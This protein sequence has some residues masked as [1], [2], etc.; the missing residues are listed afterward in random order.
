MKLIF[1]LPLLAAAA[2]T[3]SP[4]LAE[5]ALWIAEGNGS[6][7]GGVYRVDA[8]KAGRPESYTLRLNDKKL[9]NFSITG[10]VKLPNQ[11]T[12]KIALSG[13][14]NEDGIAFQRVAKGEQI[15]VGPRTRANG[16]PVDEAMPF[17][18]HLLGNY[19][20]V[21]LGPL[22]EFRR[23][24]K[25]P[26]DLAMILHGSG[27]EVGELTVKPLQTGGY[28]PILSLPQK[29]NATLETWI[30][31][32]LPSSGFLESRGVPFFFSPAKALDVAT[33]MSG[34]KEP[35]RNKKGYFAEST[36]NT[37]GRVGLKIPGDQFSALHLLA[38][39]PGREGHVPRMTV[40]VGFYGNSSGILED[41]VVEVPRLAGGEKT[42]WV[43]GEFP[44]TLPD[45]K[46]G[47]VYHLRV[48][49]AKTANVREFEI[50]DL[51]FTRD[52]NT[53]V[54]PPDPNEFGKIA[55][56]YP[57][58]A[59]VLAAS[60]E[61]S[62]VTMV[63]TTKE[64][65]N[66]FFET[67]KAE[68]ELTLSNRSS[69]PQTIIAYATGAGPG[70]GEEYGIEHTPFSV[71][72]KV[73]LAPGETR[74]IT[75]DVTQKRRGWYRCSVGIKQDGAVLQQRE[76]TFGIL[77]PDTRKAG[78]ES[79]FGSWQ[80]WNAHSVRPTAD[81]IDRLASLMHKA[82]FR[83][84]YGGVP[85]LSRGETPDLDEVYDRLRN[86]YKIS[87]TIQNLPKS[88]Q[89][90]EGWWNRE[91][92]ET[93]VKPAIETGLRRSDGYFKV[94]HESRSSP[95]LIRRFSPYFGGDPY[96]MPAEEKARLDRQVENVTQYT[97]ALKQADPRAKVV[98]INDYPAFA[99]QYL[100]RK[101]PP[102]NFDVIGLEG[103]MF[104]RAPERQPDWMSLLGLLRE[105]RLSMEKHGYKKP[106]WTTE[107]LYHPTEAGALSLH[108]QATINVR[109]AMMA[110]QLG[111]ERMA[112]A[113]NIQDYSDDYHWTNWGSV[114]H[115]YRD[116]EFN[117][118]PSYLAYAWLTQILDQAKP[119][120]KIP[121][122]NP[123]LHLV[124]FVKP[125]G[126]H[127]YGLWTAGGVQEVR[128]RYAGGSQPVVYD[129]YGNRVEQTKVIAASTAPH[130]VEGAVVEGI[131]AVEPVELP[132]PN[133]GDVVTEFD[134][135]D[136]FE[137]VQGT[138]AVLEKNWE[139][140]YL[141]GGFKT[142]WVTVDNATALKVELQ[143]DSDP[144]KLFP[145]YIELKFK[146]PVQLPGRPHELVF[147]VKGNSGWG[148]I[149]F[150]MVDAKGRVWTSV[151]NQY[152][153]AA[154]AADPLGE[155]FVNFEGWQTM[156]F[157]VMG[158][159]PGKDQTLF[160]PKNYNWWPW[161]AP[162]IDEARKAEMVAKA[163]FDAA[164]K[165][166]EEELKRYQEAPEPKGKPPVPP[167]LRRADYNGAVPVDYPLTLTKVIVAMRPHILY[168][169]EEVPV[170]NPAI[171][172]DFLG[173]T[174]PP[175]GQ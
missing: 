115:C 150:E 22:R 165:K 105:M 172:L 132:N 70:T 113:T 50:F 118:K 65:G 9:T 159:Y 117:P 27:L 11:T 137:V 107:A 36:L 141:K 106:I 75:L 84:T 147:R 104:L 49:F 48:P 119:N 145:R 69:Q 94:L 90:E 164:T 29:A 35:F 171:Y 112:A 10:R 17:S 144:R 143:P 20:E 121:T 125:D 100:Q 173:V 163:E 62:P 46:S 174:Q 88:Y 12:L 44:V 41:V 3:F 155:S 68:F 103:A 28:F 166:Y 146:E 160:W 5:S 78:E 53:H 15:R 25:H 64:A 59:V 169:D 99:D 148:R 66:V 111:V 26:V 56:G 168:L 23:V 82:G 140:R 33:S 98:L 89:R 63:Y 139:T 40:R 37:F 91:V 96:E 73:K 60:L 21:A 133:R 123:S 79:P 71:E 170:K 153:G 76:T 158:M 114:G 124:D 136:E 156:R 87:F 142:E 72:R 39:A 81:Q 157:S 67:Q 16:S 85:S 83:H 86:E 108:Q 77:A 8:R 52:I 38:V 24:E 19:L 101:F 110:L 51:E 45:S 135:P 134:R 116:P 127:V 128:L 93:L 138:N 4:L 109:E 122:P 32:G 74:Q 18:I 151:G 31:D 55:A 126:S 149:L 129:L 6:E 1:F 14:P 61:P 162:E 152:D 120:G 80:F 102:E 13:D 92:F 30:R 57:S 161:P 54:I 2:A 131:E 95:Q 43:I 130:Y 154:N 167:R 7:A 58:D 175:E 42:P 47:T 34:A 97:R